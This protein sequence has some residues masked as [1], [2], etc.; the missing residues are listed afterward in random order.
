MI[1]IHAGIDSQELRNLQRL[2]SSLRSNTTKLTGKTSINVAGKVKQYIGSYASNEYYIS[3]NEV[4]NAIKVLRGGVGQEA[5]LHLR[6]RKFSLIR[7]Y[8]NSSRTSPLQAGV[9]RG[10]SKVISR[11]FVMRA[12]N[13]VQHVF[14]RKYTDSKLKNQLDVLR[15]VS[16]PEMAGTPRALEKIDRFMRAE[17]DR[18]LSPGIENILRGVS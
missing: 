5:S 17:I 4:T 2:F 6:G 1:N 18:E 13:G 16:I 8:V 11:A 12:S 14:F 9:L 3:S 15:A 10:N 7:F